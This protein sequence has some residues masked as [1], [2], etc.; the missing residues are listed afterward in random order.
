VNVHLWEKLKAIVRRHIEGTEHGIHADDDGLLMHG[1]QLT[2]M[3]SQINGK[4]VTPREGKAVEVQALWYNALRTMQL[5]ANRFK[6]KNLAQTYFQ[7][8]KES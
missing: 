5:L 2:W 1:P 6:E 4:A 8:V 7:H 3:D